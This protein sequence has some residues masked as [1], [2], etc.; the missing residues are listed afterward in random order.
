[1]NDK[2]IDAAWQRFSSMVVPKEAGENQRE[3][4]RKA[5]F[6][7]ASVLLG[8]I[9]RHA[10]DKLL[11]ELSTEVEEFGLSLRMASAKGPPPPEKADA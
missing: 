7:G 10:D 11:T 2:R 4:M 8:L 5:F 9:L 1:M 3:D 6:S